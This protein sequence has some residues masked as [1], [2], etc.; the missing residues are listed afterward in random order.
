MT[1]LIA[2]IMTIYLIGALGTCW[3]MGAFRSA[4]TPLWAIILWPAFWGLVVLRAVGLYWRWHNRV[5]LRLANVDFLDG[6][7]VMTGVPM[8]AAAL[9]EWC[10]EHNVK[11][12]FDMEQVCLW[13][14]GNGKVISLK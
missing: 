12:A 13:R 4:R 11:A 6:R 9:A 7:S 2:M 8:N 10:T 14:V 5:V 3:A 1:A